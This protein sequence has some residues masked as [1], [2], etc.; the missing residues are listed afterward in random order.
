MFEIL[1]QDQVVGSG[2]RTGSKSCN[3][4]VFILLPLLARSKALR[5]LSTLQT[6]AAFWL[7]L[8]WRKQWH[9]ST[10]SKKWRPL[11]TCSARTRL[12]SYPTP[13]C[14]LAI[15]YSKGKRTQVP[16]KLELN[17][18]SLSYQSCDLSHDSSN[19]NVI[20]SF[21]KLINVSVPWPLLLD[22]SCSVRCNFSICI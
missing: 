9:F 22:A 11:D 16:L 3:R 21:Q 18:D 6:T 4:E 14:L 2:A 20:S 15:D 12:A 5:R 7:F 8:L 17:P 13:S 19:Q 10:T 1:A